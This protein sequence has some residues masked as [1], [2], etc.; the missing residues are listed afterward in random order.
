MVHG[1]DY[2]C[3]LCTFRA[4]NVVP[5]EQSRWAYTTWIHLKNSDTSRFTRQNLQVRRGGITKTKCNFI[6]LLELDNISLPNFPLLH[7]QVRIR[8]AILT[9]VRE[10]KPITPVPMR[11][12]AFPRSIIAPDHC[13]IDNIRGMLRAMYQSKGLISLQKVLDTIFQKRSFTNL[14]G[15][16]QFSVQCV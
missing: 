6:G 8:K 10:G 7:L 14:Y 4:Q 16:L 3:N 9:A 2:P 11:I 1:A 15:P 12:N 13:C 5:S